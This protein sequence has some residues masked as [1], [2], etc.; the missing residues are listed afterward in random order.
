MKNRTP[1]GDGGGGANHRG[2]SEQDHSHDRAATMQIQAIDALPMPGDLGSIPTH[3]PGGSALS[4]ERAR[5]LTDQIRCDSQGVR[6]MLLRAYEGSAHLVLGYESFGQY[7]ESEFSISSSRAYRSL[8]AARVENV[9]IPNTGNGDI[10][11]SDAVAHEL[12]SLLDDPEKLRE[13]FQT[14]VENAPRNKI[15]VVTVTAPHVAQ[16]LNQDAAGKPATEPRSPSRAG[17]S[18]S[19]A[20][21]QVI[22]AIKVHGSFES[23]LDAVVIAKKILSH[24]RLGTD[25]KALADCVDKLL[26]AIGTLIS[27][28]VTQ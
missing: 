26:D 10:Q 7:C 17:V 1:P 16:A 8:E 19:E 27:L 3:A 18:V 9:L 6:A 12:A 15:G 20:I 25:P 14:A 11:V 21:S 13:T 5:Q 4:V 24:R 22:E 28:R 2:K 23:T